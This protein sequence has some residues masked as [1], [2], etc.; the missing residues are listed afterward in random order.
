MNKELTERKEVKEKV[1]IKDKRKKKIEKWKRKGKKVSTTTGDLKSDTFSRIV[2]GY[3]AKKER[4]EI[5]KT[6]GNKE[7]LERLLIEGRINGYKEKD[8]R[9]IEIILKYADDKGCIKKIKRISKPSRRVYYGYEK[10]KELQKE[11]KMLIVSTSKGILSGI[12]LEK[13]KIGGELIAEIE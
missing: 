4:I 8:P 6:R 10:L 11:K 7:I 5:I 2:N 13:E 1:V 12:D 3:R 9:R